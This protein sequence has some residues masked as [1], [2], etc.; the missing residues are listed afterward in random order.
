[1]ANSTAAAISSRTAS[2]SVAQPG[3]PALRVAGLAE[4][5]GP[6]HG[7]LRP[8]DGRRPRLGVR[9]LG[10]CAP[11]APAGLRWGVVDADY[12][13]PLGVATQV[14]AVLEP[15]GP[16]ELE[17]DEGE[18]QGGGYSPRWAAEARL[19]PALSSLPLPVGS[20]ASDGDVGTVGLSISPRRWISRF[21]FSGFRISENCF[22]ALPELGPGDG[23]VA[24]VDVVVVV[25][26]RE[27]VVG[28]EVVHQRDDLVRLHRPLEL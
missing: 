27:G 28:P 21:H 13:H 10:P 4:R 5:L 1:M 22:E 11:E 9:V 24:D 19:P 3:Q 16:R 18:E 14:A 20:A 8:G 26:H 6:H 23:H 7:Q 25:G 17:L 15:D 2:L 12:Q